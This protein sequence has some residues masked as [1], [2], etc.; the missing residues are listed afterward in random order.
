M[1]LQIYLIQLLRPVYMFFP[2]TFA[3]MRNSGTS[4]LVTHDQHSPFYTIR[5]VTLLRQRSS[6]CAERKRETHP[7]FDI[8]S[9]G[10]SMFRGCKVASRRQPFEGPLQ[11]VC[12]SLVL[13]YKFAPQLHWAA[14]A[15]VWSITRT[16]AGVNDILDSPISHRRLA[17]PALLDHLFIQQNTF[18]VQ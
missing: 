4:L 10:L 7:F 5:C 12:S 17:P 9:P 14:G 15:Y 2:G 6:I 11:V 3:Q 16:L 13:F 1:R 8:L 18:V